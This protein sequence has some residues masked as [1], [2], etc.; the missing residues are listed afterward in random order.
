M[1]FAPDHLIGLIKQILNNGFK[2]TN[3]SEASSILSLE[4]LHNCNNGAIH[5]HQAGKVQEILLDFAHK[6][7]KLIGT[8]M[9]P[10]L[11]LP[12]LEK[13]APED[14]NILYC[15]AVGRLNYLAHASRLDIA[16]TTN[17]LSRHLNTYRREH[18]AVVKHLLHYLRGTRDMSIHY[19]ANGQDTTPRGFSNANWAGDATTRRSTSGVLFT[20]TG[21]LIYWSSKN[22]KSVATSTTKAELHALAEAIKHTIFLSNFYNNLRL[23][24][25]KRIP[26]FCNNQSTL[27]IANSK[28][29]E[30]HQRSKHYSV[31]LTLTRDNLVKDVISLHYLPTKTMPTNLLT[32]A[33]SKGRIIELNE[34]L[35]LNRSPLALKG[36]VVS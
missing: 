9:E 12:K 32:K 5:L 3:L 24:H 8:P 20:L 4:I 14:I 10:G 16:F 23:N 25:R 11:Q 17:V 26:I 30:H 21:G 19:S 2:M 6:N 7:A 1:I 13:T 29:S 22:Q 36:R 15:S 27:T 34:I 35:N 18:W 31:K 33:L 28:P